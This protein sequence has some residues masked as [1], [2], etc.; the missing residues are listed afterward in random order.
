LAKK[1]KAEKPQHEMTRRRLAQW[2][3][4][5]RRQRII[6]YAGIFIIA[7]IV[8]TVLAGWYASGYRPFHQTAIKVYDT[9]FDMRYY[10][11]TLRLAARSQPSDSTQS[12]A[13]YLQGIAGNV[14]TQIEQ[15]E[16]IKQ[17]ASQ[18]N[19][20]VSDDEAR[21]Q[22]AGSAIPVNHASLDLVRSQI[23][24]GRIYQ[25]YLDSQVPES[26]DQVHIMAMF[27]ENES[28]A[29]EVRDRLVNSNNISDNFT[30]QAAALS[31]DSYSKDN[32]GDIGWHPQE[33]LTALL[34][35]SVPG[36]YAFGSEVGVLS[37]PRLDADK[38][39][40]VGYWLVRV[41]SRQESDM[42]AQ[43]EAILLGSQQEALDVKARIEA[44]EDFASLAK[45]F[46]QLSGA[47]DNGGELGL[48]SQSD[49]SPA[50]GEYVFDLAIK[51]G[52]LSEPIRDDT[53][54][55]KGGYWLIRVVDRDKD[56]PLDQDDRNYLLN[57]A[58]YDWVSTLWV[59]ASGNVDN[60]YLDAQKNAWAI[61][62]AVK[63]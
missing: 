10:I 41:V 54:S 26:A 47:Q 28:Q 23:L 37:Q 30:A 44:G 51:T 4:E 25:E 12:P 27:L 57:K 8:L 61:E 56:R 6:F 43:V 5:K 34:D 49:L 35:S 53:V 21:E 13:E 24:R 2:Q 17:G 50:V 40:Q 29:A 19:I 46:S 20:S 3:R 62:Q 60:S 55:T 33:I 45:Q 14:V 32:K 58:F 22:L 59:A 39:K 42:D 11:D 16:L 18:L 63:G 38:M 15:N 7:A 36:D 52:T 48:M 1:K 31:L 9:K